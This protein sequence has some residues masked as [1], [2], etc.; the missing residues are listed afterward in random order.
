MGYNPTLNLA[1]RGPALLHFLCIAYRETRSQD[2]AEVL[3][4]VLAEMPNT[5]PLGREGENRLSCRSHGD[6]RILDEDVRRRSSCLLKRLQ[7]PLEGLP[8]CV[9][10]DRL[11]YNARV[12]L[13]IDNNP[14][15][16]RKAIPVLHRGVVVKEHRAIPGC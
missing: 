8:H 10:S 16:E 13:S 11:E 14:K 6:V 5:P 7:H 4:D 1:S 2:T 9:G 12:V 3:R 15:A